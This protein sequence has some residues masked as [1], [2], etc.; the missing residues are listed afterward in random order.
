[1]PSS[2]CMNLIIRVISFNCSSQQSRIQAPEFC[3]PRKWECLFWCCMGSD[4]FSV[5]WESSNKHF[6]YIWGLILVCPVSVKW[7]LLY[8]QNTATATSISKPIIFCVSLLQCSHRW[9]PLQVCECHCPAT[10]CHL[11]GC[12]MACAL[13]S[14]AC[15]GLH[16][17]LSNVR[18]KKRLKKPFSVKLI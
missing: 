2:C 4:H 6:F 1:M 17:R 16:W 5:L 13:F 9:P 18:K 3:H 8:Y 10:P 11:L 7:D 12:A 14:G 15:S